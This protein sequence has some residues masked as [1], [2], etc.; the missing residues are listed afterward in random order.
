MAAEVA[1]AV[2]GFSRDMHAPNGRMLTNGLLSMMLAAGTPP[3][4]TLLTGSTT[5]ALGA[6]PKLHFNVA[7]MQ[8]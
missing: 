7:P 5:S 8:T 4:V 1:A 2:V 3:V 6:I